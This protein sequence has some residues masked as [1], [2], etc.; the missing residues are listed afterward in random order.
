MRRRC[1]LDA[2]LS[3]GSRRRRPGFTWHDAARLP[4]R[5][6][7]AGRDD[8]RDEQ[9]IAFRAISGQPRRRRRCARHDITIF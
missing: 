5:A 7:I 8:L 1:A 9:M 4:A 3:G 6:L 2:K